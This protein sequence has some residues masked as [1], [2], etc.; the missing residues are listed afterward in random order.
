[1]N[2]FFG[3]KSWLVL[4]AVLLI[5]LVLVGLLLTKAPRNARIVDCATGYH[6]ITGADSNCVPNQ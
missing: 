5:G 2:V 3:R 4:V 1:M 6:N